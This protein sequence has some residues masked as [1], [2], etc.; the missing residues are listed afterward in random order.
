MWLPEEEN[1]IVSTKNYNA[2]NFIVTTVQQ[3]TKD[4]LCLA[5]YCIILC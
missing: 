3:I 4:K 1:I 5:I 2:H